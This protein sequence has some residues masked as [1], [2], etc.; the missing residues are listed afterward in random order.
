MDENMTHSDILDIFIGDEER[1][2][3]SKEERKKRYSEYRQAQKKLIEGRQQPLTYPEAELLISTN[4]YDKI[5]PK[6][7]IALDERLFWSFNRK[8][9]AQKEDRELNLKRTIRLYR[10]WKDF[11]L[12]EYS[13]LECDLKEQADALRK[14][15]LGDI[16]ITT[17]Q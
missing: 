11:D 4:W 5:Y 1:P 2:Q 16:W 15:S 17:E 8:T 12:E 9:K 6:R 10:T 13:D 7:A 14:A 3:I